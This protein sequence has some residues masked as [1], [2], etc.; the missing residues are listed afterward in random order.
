MTMPAGEYYVG[1]LCYVLTDRWDE[2]CNI[3]IS[4]HEV[5]NGE[6]ELP[7][8]TRF[9]TYSTAH[10]DGRYEDDLENEYPVDAGL[11]GCVLLSDI[12]EEYRDRVDDCGHVYTFVKPF[13]TGYLDRE[14][15]KI[16]FDSVVIDTDPDYYDEDEADYY[17]E[18]EDL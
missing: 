1:D 7:D 9:A 3:T 14:K 11:I 6:F 12:S 2:F 10:G 8:G 17:D 4:G 18:D 16:F 5:L 13:V 15:T